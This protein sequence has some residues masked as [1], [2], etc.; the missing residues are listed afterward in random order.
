MK[1]AKKSLKVLK[2]STLNTSR[3]L[4]PQTPLSKNEKI[5]SRTQQSMNQSVLS[6]KSD[7]LKS[8]RL[9]NSFYNDHSYI[10]QSKSR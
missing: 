9:A 10:Y 3:P 2:E 4:L 1:Q 8:P 7:S 6:V 5:R